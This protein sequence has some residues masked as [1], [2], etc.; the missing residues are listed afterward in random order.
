MLKISYSPEA[1]NALREVFFYTADNWGVPQARKYQQDF[2]EAFEIIAKT[3]NIGKNHQQISLEY[4]IFPVN[5]H[6]IIYRIAESE[7]FIVAI[8]HMAMDVEERL[9]K[10]LEN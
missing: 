2:S 4:R 6:L 5:K 3:P 7:L 8:I 10:L 9:Q 1:E